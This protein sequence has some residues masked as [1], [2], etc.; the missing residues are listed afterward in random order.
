MDSKIEENKTM[1]EEKS[2][3]EFRSTGLL[4]FV[5]SFLQIFGWSIV[6]SYDKDKDTGELKDYRVF[7]AR[8]KFRG[9]KTESVS[10]AHVKLAEWMNQNH[11]QLLREA[12]DEY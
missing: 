5:N 3:E 2:W 4:L 11:E 6:V 7:P 12:K 10:K 8:S 1:V 9:F